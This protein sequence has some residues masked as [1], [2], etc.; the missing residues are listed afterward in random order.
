[1]K[2]Y[3][4]RGS[5]VRKYLRLFQAQIRLRFQH[6]SVFRLDFFGPFFVDGSMFVIQLLA[7]QA[8]Y[9]NVDTVGTWGKGEMILYI[10][11]FNLLNALSM[12][13]CFFGLSSIPD[14]VKN[15]EMDLYLSKP[16]SPLFRLTFEKVNPGSVPLIVMSLCIIGYGIQTAGIKPSVET[17]SAYVFWMT[18]MAILYYDMEVLVRSVSFYLVSNARLEQL[19]SACLELCMKLPG[20]AFYGG[21]KVIFYYLLPYGIMATIPVQSMIEELTFTGA[22]Q[23]IGITVIFT[24][25]MAVVWKRG[26]RRYNSA[27]S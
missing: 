23:G 4:A 26:L 18:L 24:L 16:A 14:K 6:L 9:A 10:G 2:K 21:Y 5:I 11:S 12:T 3:C 19:E 25:L 15:G 7:F 20:I 13:I 22:V 1:M 8:V 27:S 17:V